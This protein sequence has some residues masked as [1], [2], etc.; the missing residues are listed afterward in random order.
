[1][2]RWLLCSLVGLCLVVRAQE[3]WAQQFNPQEHGVR[4]HD[5]FYF[6]WA[7]GP[8]YVFD[9]VDSNIV[10]DASIAGFGVAD[11]LL[12]GG[13]PA[14]GL[15]VGGGTHG[16]TAIAPSLEIEG[17]SAEAPRL[18]QL[19]SL[20][21]FAD[22]YF[23]PHAGWHAQVFI[24]LSVLAAD[25]SAVDENPFG[26]TFAIAGGHEWWIGEQWGAGVLLRLLYSTMAFDDSAGG[27][28]EHHSVIAPAIMGSLTYH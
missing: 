7:L 27:V 26:V 10:G 24:G 16:A 3:S 4:M 6:R 1:M 5:G 19:S 28:E 12:F 18:L 22:Y 17:E 15:V 11:E 25:N 9:G 2:R 8:G 14:P 20:G 13:T 23:H 21:A